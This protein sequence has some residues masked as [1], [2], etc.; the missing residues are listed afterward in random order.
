MIY[1]L[2]VENSGMGKDRDKYTIYE[3]YTES[4][5]TGLSKDIRKL[6]N[7]CRM[8]PKNMDINSGELRI[9]HWP[10]G[11]RSKSSADYILLAKISET[12]FKLVTRSRG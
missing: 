10:Y 1:I 12:R 6:I 5:I 8:E 11:I 9:N 3:T 4:L 7:D 2:R